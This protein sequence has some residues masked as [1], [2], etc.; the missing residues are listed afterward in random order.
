MNVSH[1]SVIQRDDDPVA[2]GRFF[3]AISADLWS[4]GI[5]ANQQEL[6]FPQAENPGKPLSTR[7]QLDDIS[8]GQ[9]HH[10]SK[11]HCGHTSPFT[12]PAEHVLLAGCS[13]SACWNDRCVLSYTVGLAGEVLLSL[14]F[15]H[16]SIR[17]VLSVGE[18]GDDLVQYAL[19][20]HIW[21]W[22]VSTGTSGETRAFSQIQ[23]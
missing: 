22:V 19:L 17:H 16:A 1:V 20:S 23:T 13:S 14:A 6:G 15:C 5:G 4:S 7:D 10:A 18:E 12:H 3:K 8:F 11:S 2:S 9:P 21:S